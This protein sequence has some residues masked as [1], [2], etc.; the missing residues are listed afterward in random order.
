MVTNSVGPLYY[1]KFDVAKFD[2]AQFDY[3][4]FGKI[5]E[6]ENNGSNDYSVTWGAYGFNGEVGEKWVQ[7]FTIGTRGDN[8]TYLCSYLRLGLLKYDLSVNSGTVTI[9][10]Y[11]TSGGRPTGSALGTTTLNAADLQ[12]QEYNGLS[13]ALVKYQNI[14]FSTPIKLSPSTKYAIVVTL[15]PEAADKVV[16]LG[17]NT[18]DIYTGGTFSFYFGDT[19]QT[20]YDAT[21]SVLFEV[22]GFPIVEKE[23]TA[24]LVNR[25]TKDETGRAKVLIQKTKTK[26]ANS[27][28]RISRTKTQTGKARI[29][30]SYSKTYN[31]NSRIKKTQSKT[32]IT[33]ARIKISKSKTINSTAR[34]TKQFT[35]T[36][37]ANARIKKLQSKLIYSSARIKITGYTKQ[38]TGNVRI[39]Q[40]QEPITKDANARIKV[41]T[42]KNVDGSALLKGTATRTR[43]GTARIKIEGYTKQST[44]AAFVVFSPRAEK[45]SNARIQKDFTK[46][47]NANS[48]I[49][50]SKEKSQTANSR[51]KIIYT[52]NADSES[53]IAIS[54]TKINTAN[55][56]ISKAI[57]K[58]KTGTARILDTERPKGYTGNARIIFGSATK[59]YDGNAYIIGESGANV[60]LYKT[61]PVSDYYVG[62]GPTKLSIVG[63]KEFTLTDK[64]EMVVNPFPKVKARQDS[65]NS[66]QFDVKVIDL[67]QGT[68]SFVVRGILVDD[69]NES[70]WNKAWKLRAMCST[71]GPVEIFVLEDKVF[72]DASTMQAFIT[73][74][75]FK[76]IQDE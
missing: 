28:I 73:D 9:G 69:E 7:T 57:I 30:K 39:A 46:T 67:K 34:L 58:S 71:G 62:N 41:P 24:F 26:T 3:S 29:K 76:R 51:I 59:T 68:Q 37:S 40:T 75:K 63:A 61:L 14:N 74:V 55:A 66:D 38:V 49:L 35:K 18:D 50:I 10:I 2:R 15:S 44:G 8:G 6:W 64:K 60:I 13:Q 72:R 27:R 21:D 56:R 48:R 17:A 43:F 32:Q 53:R 70:A 65:D 16:L 22:Y 33:N 47:T 25:R 23:G 20:W 19:T 36:S 42:S 52:K 45:D 54:K 31:A 12:V 5:L 11:N 4:G 1:S